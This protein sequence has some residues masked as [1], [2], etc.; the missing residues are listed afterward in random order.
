MR[1]LAIVFDGGFI[2]YLINVASLVFKLSFATGNCDPVFV[3]DKKRTT[4]R[5]VSQT[6]S[7]TEVLPQHEI[8]EIVDVDTPNFSS[9]LYY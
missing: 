5:S 3:E 6:S 9:S 8:V 2:I 7:I 4:E 1:D